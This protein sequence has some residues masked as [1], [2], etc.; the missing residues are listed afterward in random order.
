LGAIPAQIQPAYAGGLN[1]F[2]IGASEDGVPQD[3]VT[4]IGSATTFLGWELDAEVFLTPSAGPWV[5]HFVQVDPTGSETFFFADVDP[6]NDPFPVG[7][8]T[9]DRTVFP[10]SEVLL[11]SGPS[12]WG[13]WHERVTTSGFE[14][15]TNPLIRINFL[16]C[17]PP[18]C[19]VSFPTPFELK[20]DFDPALS[21][22]DILLIDKNLVYVGPPPF[23][24]FNF[25]EVEQF[26]TPFIPGCTSNDECQDDLFCNGEEI[27]N[28][29]SGLC[30]SGTPADCSILDDQCG[31][32]IC[33]LISD[34]CIITPEN[35][36]GICDDGDACTT[37]DFCLVG[38]CMGG[39]PIVC[40]DDGNACTNDLGCNPA[41]GSCT[42][43]D[44]VCAD[45]GNACTNDLGCDPD[46]GSCIFE[47]VPISPPTFCDDGNACTPEGVCL[48]AQC[49]VI[50]TTDCSAS[51]NECNAAMCDPDSGCFS[52][53]TNEGGSCDDG[54]SG[55]QNDVCTGGMCS[56]DSVSNDT[57]VR[58]ISKTCTET[59][60]AS[61][62]KKF[63]VTV[64]GEA[65]DSQGI[66]KIEVIFHFPDPPPTPDETRLVFENFGTLNNVESF[67]QTFELDTK[68]E[69]I[70][71]KITDGDGNETTVDPPLECTPP[72]GAGD[73]QGQSTIT[74][75]C[76]VIAELEINDV[77]NQLNLIPSGDI[78][79]FL[80]NP[81]N[82]PARYDATR[83][84][85]TN[86]DDLQRDCTLKFSSG[87]LS[88]A[89]KTEL[90]GPVS[91]PTT[92]AEVVEAFDTIFRDWQWRMQMSV[93]QVAD[94]AAAGL[95]QKVTV[96]VDAICDRDD[97]GNPNQV[98]PDFATSFNGDCICDLTGNPPNN[99]A[100]PNPNLD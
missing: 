82:A 93:Q 73:V 39:S 49:F 47:D 3:F 79:V 26:P 14:W 24:S 96:T 35:N 32:G 7:D 87:D 46:T 28:L 38:R 48:G 53:P 78:R 83:T 43:E 40:A 8:G 22:G 91:P 42:F 81:G 72:P 4:V 80:E 20:I 2:S 19:S 9:G 90:P 74:G 92:L 62:E 77:G 51:A 17:G 30:E 89:A 33:D 75:T 12:G 76:G 13:D 88:F 58:D 64:S 65:A 57:D 95:K 70:E 67:D 31:Q 36:L 6:S 71:I 86:D 37:G 61:G 16:A 98:C 52:S 45:D 23:G 18:T 68:P 97:F 66:K 85:C 5:K 100:C 60:D 34:S 59:T 41:T 94:D 25:I 44:V 21:P 29:D 50:G 54:N 10:I 1:S 55:T 84:T 63:E 56:G 27:C 11:V 69:S 15:D 99:N